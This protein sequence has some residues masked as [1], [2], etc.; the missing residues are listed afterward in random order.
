MYNFYH[1][2]VKYI[3]GHLH[4]YPKYNTVAEIRPWYLY[5][6]IEYF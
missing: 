4:N 2:L 5:R 1:E 6:Y 3:I